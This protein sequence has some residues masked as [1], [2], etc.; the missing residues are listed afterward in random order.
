LGSTSK[1]LDCTVDCQVNEAVCKEPLNAVIVVGRLDVGPVS[2]VELLVDCEVPV[3][4][5]HSDAATVA[6][7]LKVIS[8]LSVAF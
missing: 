5:C 3:F 1:Q 7:C 4:G 2:S 8:V 6:L